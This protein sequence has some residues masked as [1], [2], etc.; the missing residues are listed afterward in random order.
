MYY[1]YYYYYYYSSCALWTK[2]EFAWSVKWK[3]GK[4]T[5]GDNYI[6]TRKL[7]FYISKFSPWWLE[8]FFFVPACGTG[9]GSSSSLVKMGW[10]KQ[11]KKTVLFSFC[12][13]VPRQ[14]PAFLTFAFSRPLLSWLPVKNPASDGRPM[15]SHL[16][17]ESS[18]L[19]YQAGEWG[20][21]NRY[22]R[23]VL[24]SNDIDSK[25]KPLP[26]QS[27]AMATKWRH[28][29][30]W[31]SFT[32]KENR[33]GL[34]QK[35]GDREIEEAQ[36]CPCQLCHGTHH[37]SVISIKSGL[38]DTSLTWTLKEP[39]WTKLYEEGMLAPSNR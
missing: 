29:Y 28:K 38:P 39:F 27:P 18:V 9:E 16:N 6:F 2:Q 11:A 14:K 23:K 17:T 3:E 32:S 1:Y 25:H 34:E 19:Q 5:T 20:P 21:D 37:V 12:T 24:I 10:Q 30:H 8:P 33:R 26:L 35:R 36:L 22:N 15:R 7:L 31:W 13:N 4:W